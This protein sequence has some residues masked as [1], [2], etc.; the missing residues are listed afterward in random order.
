MHAVLAPHFDGVQRSRT[1]RQPFEALLDQILD[2]VGFEDYLP[3]HIQRFS[4]LEQQ[5]CQVAMVFPTV[6]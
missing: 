5:F 3:G 4:P 2:A 6:T 1:G